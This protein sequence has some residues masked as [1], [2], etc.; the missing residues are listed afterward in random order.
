[1]ARKT[2]VT[3]TSKD[4]GAKHAGRFN[5]AVSAIQAPGEVSALAGNDAQAIKNVQNEI[6]SFTTVDENHTVTGYLP[7][8]GLDTDTN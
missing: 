3:N 5:S 8:T 2:S 1:M 7:T 4:S 6:Y